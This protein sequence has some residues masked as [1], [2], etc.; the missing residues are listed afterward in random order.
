[1]TTTA[2]SLIAKARQSGTPLI[3]RDLW[4]PDWPVRLMTFVVGEG[5]PCVIVRR[6][7]PRPGFLERIELLEE[8]AEQRLARYAISQVYNR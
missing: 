1:M 5:N 6:V 2:L 7:G 3:A 8:D 4:D